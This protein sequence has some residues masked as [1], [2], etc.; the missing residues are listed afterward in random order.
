MRTFQN[1]FVGRQRQGRF[2]QPLGLGFVVVELL[3]QPVDVTVLEVVLR[4]LNLVLVVDIAVGN[5]FRP[6]QIEDVLHALQ[7]HGETLKTVGDFAQYRL[8]GQTADFLEVG[9]LCHLHAIEPYLPAEAPGAERGRFPVV[10]DEAD[11]VFFCIDADGAQRVEIEVLDVVRRRLEHHLV[12]VVMLQ[13]VGVVAVAPILGAARGLHVRR[14]PRFR[15]DGAQERRG[16]ERARAHLH[17]VRLQ[18]HAA[19][20]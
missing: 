18:Q 17:V 14:L 9:E 5:A 7:I 13:A 8:A 19:L 3:K 10:L 12:L 11:V 20:A 15:A 16:V 1:H 6:R 2:H 4:L